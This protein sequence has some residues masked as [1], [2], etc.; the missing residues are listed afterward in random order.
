MENL[1][2]QTI[3]LTAQ[4]TEFNLCQELLQMERQFDCIT[5]LSLLSLIFKR[6]IKNDEL[7]QFLEANFLRQNDYK[8]MSFESLFRLLDDETKD[9]IENKLY[10]FKVITEEI[11]K[12]LDDNKKESSVTINDQVYNVIN[13]I[14]TCI[15]A[16]YKSGGESSNMQLE[17]QNVKKRKYI[18]TPTVG[19]ALLNNNPYS[20]FVNKVLK[21]NSLDEWQNSIDARFHGEIIHSIMEIFA[22]KCRNILSKNNLADTMERLFDEVVKYVVIKNKVVINGFL[23]KKL[24]NI[25]DVAI[26]LEKECFLENRTAIV[27]KKYSMMI[28]GVK[29]EAKADRIEVN[30]MN[31]SLYIYDYKTGNLPTDKQEN[32]GEKTQLLIIAT[33]LLNQAEYL[34]YQVKRLVYVDLSG[35]DELKLHNEYIDIANISLTEDRLKAMVNMYFENGEPIVQKM[36]YIE[37]SG[38]IYNNDIEMMKFYREPFL[39]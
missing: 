24:L 17:I 36:E 30:K 12:Y 15:D 20:F 13:I 32:N 33:I 5:F 3:S 1:D 7:V 2:I 11:Y 18:L 35:K 39:G 23:Q 14:E 34:D 10:I 26:K 31:K 28:D 6:K 19:I 27:E 16:N 4:Q 21:I 22:L 38:M 25:K 8:I 29:I 9:F 37:P